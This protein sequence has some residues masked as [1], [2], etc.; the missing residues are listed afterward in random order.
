L[1]RLIAAGDKTRMRLRLFDLYIAQY[2]EERERESEREREREREREVPIN[3]AL[4]QF[5]NL[6]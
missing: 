3:N 1:N 4:T 2:K 6:L 5:V